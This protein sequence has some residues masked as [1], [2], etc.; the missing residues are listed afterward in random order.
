MTSILRQKRALRCQAAEF[1]F[2]GRMVMD[3]AVLHGPHLFGLQLHIPGLG[4]C[5][6]FSNQ[7]GKSE[8]RRSF[9]VGVVNR[10]ES[11]G[12]GRRKR[13]T[14]RSGDGLEMTLYHVLQTRFEDRTSVDGGRWENITV[15]SS[16]VE[17]TSR[18][19]GVDLMVVS[20]SKGSL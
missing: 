4:N 17:R 5:L 16:D 20:G 6:L 9:V 18:A 12:A 3:V 2:H 7:K 14:W 10:E 19:A 15:R 8:V 13:E 1:R 11:L